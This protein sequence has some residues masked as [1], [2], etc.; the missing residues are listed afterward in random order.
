MAEPEWK[1]DELGQLE[2][3]SL[4][5][6]LQALNQGLKSDGSRGAPEAYLPE[7]RQLWLELEALLPEPGAGDRPC[8]VAAR[9]LITNRRVVSKH[10]PMLAITSLSDIFRPFVDK[11]TQQVRLKKIEFK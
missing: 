3:A 8:E 1:T 10:Q 7:T 2:E 4:K 6:G 9:K 5:L 11:C